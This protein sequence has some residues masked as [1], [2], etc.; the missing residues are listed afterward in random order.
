MR[1]ST[2]HPMSSHAANDGQFQGARMILLS[3]RHHYRPRNIEDVGHLFFPLAGS[4]SPMGRHIGSIAIDLRV[5][6]QH[7]ACGTSALRVASPTLA[8]GP[9]L[10]NF[11]PHS[12]SQA[13]RPL[14]S[15][16]PPTTFLGMTRQTERDTVPAIAATPRGRRRRPQ[17]L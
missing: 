5:N 9:A 12:R 13:L 15:P 14:K 16:A 6:R 2:F 17:C 7:A 1:P 10:R 11:R 3:E 8:I 4:S